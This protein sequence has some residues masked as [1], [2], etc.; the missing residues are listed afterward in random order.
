MDRYH[1]HDHDFRRISCL[2]PVHVLLLPLVNLLFFFG[3]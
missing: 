3:Y 2:L 1:P